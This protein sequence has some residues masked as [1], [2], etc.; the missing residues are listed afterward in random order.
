M[1]VGLF[2]TVVIIVLLTLGF[3]SAAVAEGGCPPGQY[4][5]NGQGWQSCVPIPGGAPGSGSASVA[6]IP[7]KWSPKWGAIAT[8]G[9]GFLGVSAEMP[10]ES[11]A[12]GS[13]IDDCRARGGS[14]CRMT[15]VYA[16]Q[17]VAVIGRP[18]APADNVDGSNE[19]AAITNGMAK[20]DAEGVSGCWV[21]Y[22]GCSLPIEV[23]Q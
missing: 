15:H 19:K 22:S 17:C 4:P 9:R 14:N 7:S 5:Q 1:V 8:G 13:A 21:Y 16:N 11:S 3:D 20:C 18:G 12:V 23:P 10:D 6:P 2:R